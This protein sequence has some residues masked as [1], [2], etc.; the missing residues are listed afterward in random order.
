MN[1]HGAPG[2]AYATDSRQDER[3][4][5]PFGSYRNPT[6]DFS[7]QQQ[8]MRVLAQPLRVFVPLKSPELLAFGA[9][10]LLSEYHEPS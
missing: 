2:D 4:P 5:I 3:R 6:L 8:Q 9:P 1:V 10:R 7:Q